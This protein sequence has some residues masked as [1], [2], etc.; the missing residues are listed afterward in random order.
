MQYPPTPKPNHP[1]LPAK[2]NHKLMFVLCRECG[3][4]MNTEN[5]THSEE[6]RSLRGAWVLEEVVKAIQ[7]GYQVC[8]IQEIWKYDV[9]QYNP[10]TKNGGMF[11]NMMN[12]FIK[13]KQVSKCCS[14]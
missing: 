4:S 3:E 13:Y 10:A 1:V 14:K 11:T 2:M 12:D 9:R 7:M 8:E 6:D 5:C